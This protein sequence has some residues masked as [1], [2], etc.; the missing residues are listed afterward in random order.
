LVMPPQGL[1]AHLCSVKPSNFN[2][3][4]V[5]ELQVLNTTKSD[6]RKFYKKVDKNDPTTSH[7]TW[8]LQMLLK[9]MIAP[10]VRTKY[11][12]TVDSDTLLIRPV[13]HVEWLLP[14]GKARVVGESRGL[15][16]SWYN[17]SENLLHAKGCLDELNENEKMIGVTPAILHRDTM[18]STFVRLSRLHKDNIINIMRATLGAFGS[19]SSWTEYSLYRVMGCLR[20][21]FFK[22]HSYQLEL[23]D[24]PRSLYHGIWSDS[25]FGHLID[26]NDKH[27]DVVSNS[28]F[29]VLQDG[30]V[31][32]G[33]STMLRFMQ[34]L[35]CPRGKITD[36]IMVNRFLPPCTDKP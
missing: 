12:I 26:N 22:Y 31:Q 36:S 3:Y 28:L 20:A 8:R 32:E 24:T 18:V 33:T 2:L 7:N 1:N 30:H 25:E 21:D 34:K 4:C 35:F 10:R 15:H 23:P 9:V 6:V 5:D 13:K 11:F 29:I 27:E 14:H 17:A 19:K 16:G